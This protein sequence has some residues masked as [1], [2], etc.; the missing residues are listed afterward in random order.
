MPLADFF[1][2]RAK[3]LLDLE[4]DD[5]SL[6]T[7]QALAI[8]STHEGAATHDTRGWLYSGKCWD[9]SNLSALD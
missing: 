8:L 6:S 9:F 1:A 4:L 7:V 3:S 5:P 2:T